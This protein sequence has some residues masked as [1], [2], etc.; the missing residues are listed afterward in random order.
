MSNT[1]ITVLFFATAFPKFCTE[2]LSEDR[3]NFHLLHIR[4]QLFRIRIFMTGSSYLIFI[5]S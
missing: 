1:K 3:L 5:V 2:F 4:R